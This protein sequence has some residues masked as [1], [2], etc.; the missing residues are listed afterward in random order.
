MKETNLAQL[1]DNKIRTI[2]MFIA[3]LELI[4]ILVSVTYSWIEESSYLDVTGENLSLSEQFSDTIEIK[5]AKTGEEA[6]SIDLNQYFKESANFLLGE[7]SSVDGENFYFV[8]QGNDYRKGTIHDVNTSYLCFDVKIKATVGKTNIWFDGV[9][10]ITIKGKDGLSA[11][12]VRIAISD[13]TTNKVFKRD[14]TT[15]ETMAISQAGS[16]TTALQATQA[17][18]DYTYA[19]NDTDQVLFSI[20][21]GATKTLRFTLW[22]EGEDAACTDALTGEVLDVD[23]KLCTSWSKYTAVELFDETVDGTNRY[24]WILDESDVANLCLE[25]TSTGYRYL[26]EQNAAPNDYSWR[27]KIPVGL[28]TIRFLRVDNLYANY[29][30]APIFNYWTAG[31]RGNETKFTA[32]WNEVQSTFPV[33]AGVGFWGETEEITFLYT[34]QHDAK[35]YIR[36]AGSDGM[37]YFMKPN[38]SNANVF[39][40]VI[41]RGDN[42]FKFDHYKATPDIFP[43]W[44]LVRSWNAPSRNGEQKYHAYGNGTGAWGKVVQISAAASPSGGGTVS[45]N[46]TYG[47]VYVK[48]GAT[49]TLIAT[50]YTGYR[51]SHW[52][53]EPQNTTAT[54]TV[55]AGNEDA[56]YTAVFEEILVTI[57]AQA[58]PAGYGTATVNGQSSVTVRAGTQVTLK[59][60]ANSGYTFTQWNDGSTIQNRTIT[61][62]T[63]DATYTATF[64]KGIQIRLN[65]GGSALWDKDGAWFAAYYRTSGGAGKFV[66]L[67]RE[68]TSNYY[69]AY[70]TDADFS[71]KW[72]TGDGSG[73]NIQFLRMA[74][75]A[76]VPSFDTGQM[77]NKVITSYQ[78]GKTCRITDW[79][80][81]TWD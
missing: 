68:G 38:E 48:T 44:A 14:R 36:V 8:S 9:P 80:A 16:K 1:K 59:A 21:K 43:Y 64:S 47:S 35:T 51:F 69:S 37:Y 49:A 31:N 71:G 72:T 81:C 66:T 27:V 67:E 46:G 60:T 45:V 2:L 29:Q 50:P 15:G 61:A 22:L 6:N 28:T 24:R 65:S 26:M 34:Y 56:A 42:T 7:T 18:D 70:V 17:F 53:D 33:T 30:T 63:S 78:S 62:G 41:K 79:G 5:E 10:N 52:A 13:G 20:N 4:L 77:W 39:T 25:N 54:R 76:T 73:N 58:S 32:L 55:T 11:N 19:G 3:L 23:M 75:T 57:S 12:A 40:T 74:N